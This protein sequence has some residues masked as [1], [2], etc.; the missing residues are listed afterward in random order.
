MGKQ[1]FS[2]IVINGRFLSQRLTGVQRYALETVL[3]LDSMVDMITIPVELVVPQ[4]TKSNELNLKNIKVVVW[5]KRQGILWEQLDLAQYIHKNRALGVHLCNSVP[6]LTPK[7]LVCIHDITY[8][9]NP[10]FITTKHLFLAR[11]WHLMQYKIGSKKSLHIFTVSNFS[12]NQ[13]CDVYKVSK[14]KISVAYNGWQHFST[15]I[16]PPDN[17]DKFPQLSEKQYFFSL[18]TMAKNKNFSWIVESAKNNPLQKYVV[19]GNIDLKKLGDT[20]GSEL[21]QNMICLGYVTDNDAKILMKHCKAFLFPSLYE[22]FGIPPLEALAMGARVVCSN[23][24]CL[25][26][27]F[28]SSV[29]YINPLD[30]SVDLNNLLKEP[31]DLAKTVL[32]KYSWKNTG[33]VY[34]DR[35]LQVLQEDI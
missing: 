4:N 22:G 11:L 14:E 25:P 3:A 28:G 2:K 30:A 8:K 13:I 24:A 20:V 35:I 32:D 1:K 12:R 31:V 7:G 15:Q 17:L 19:A 21:P 16:E 23:A 18:A 6:I 10:Q 33:K 34:F 5:G 27:V 29:H 26:E 9:V